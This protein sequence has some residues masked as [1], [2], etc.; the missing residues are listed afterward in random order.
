MNL[1]LR[2]LWMLMSTPFRSRLAPLEV[3]VTRWRVLPGDLDA[4]GHMTN[5]RYLAVMDLARLDLLVRVGLAPLVLRHRWQV[6]VGTSAMEYRASLR[7]FEEYEVATR[8]VSWDSTWFYLRQDF[9]RPGGSSPVA[10][11]Y[12]KILF[13]GGEGPLG[14][15]D[16]LAQLGVAIARPELPRE[17]AAR[18]GAAAAAAPAEPPSAGVAMAS[19]DAAAREPLAICG[20]GC[21]LPGGI[22]DAASLWRALEER[23]DGIVEIP[24][25]RWSPERFFDPSGASA[26]RTYVQRAGLLQRDPRAFDAAFFG[27]NPREA[28]VLDPQQRL[29]LHTSWEALEDAGIPADQLAGSDTGVFI[30]GF[31]VDN[32]ILQTRPDNRGRITSAT[33]TS[34]SLTM[35]SNRLS[36]TYDLRGPSLT[37]D[38]ACSSSLV[39]LHLACQ[40]LWSGEVS[41]ALVGGVNALLV[42]ETQI[43]MAK[44][45][46]LSPRGYCHTFGAAADGY[47]RAEGAAVLVVKPLAAARRDGNPVLA[48]IR[49]TAANQDG[50]TPG[51]T[52][53]QG[54]A[55]VAVMRAAY[56]AARVEPSTVAYLEAHGTGTAAGDPI[57]ARAL[58]AV[59]GRDRVDGPCFIG[60]IKSNLGHL[61][62]ASGVTGVLKAALV[63]RERRVP[64]SLHSEELNPE[65]P[66]AELGVEVARETV[67]LAGAAPLV[68]GVNSFGYGGTNAHVVLG[69]APSAPAAPPADEAARAAATRPAIVT[70]SAKSPAALAEQAERYAAW[71]DEGGDARALARSSSVHRAHHRHRLA[72]H[73][74]LDGAPGEAAALAGAL[75]AAVRG[76]PTEESRAAIAQSS[77]RA[78]APKV[79]FVYTGMGPQWWGMCRELAAAEPVVR[80]TFEECDAIWRELAGWSLTAELA[81]DEADSRVTRTEIAQPA[82]F[83]V[84][85]ALTRLLAS[86]G[87]RPDGVIGHSVGE[88][89]VAAVS[90]GLSLRD[91]LTLAFHRSRLQAK[92]AGAGGMLAVGLSLDE[93]RARQAAWGA[94]ISVA[95]VNGP[96][97]LTLAGD[98]AVLERVAEELKAAGEFARALKVEVPYH[99]PQMEAIR[100]ELAASLRLLAA[101]A[102]ALPVYSTVTGGA[103]RGGRHDAAYWWRNVREP[104]DFVGG[105]AAAAAD[106]YDVFV[107]IGPHPVLASSIRETLRER[108]ADGE[109]VAT[110]VREAPERAALA[111]AVARLYAL[112]VT[113]DWRAYAGPGV[114]AP[115]PKVAWQLE[116][117]WVDSD[118]SARDLHGGAGHPWLGA[119]ARGASATRFPCELNL[120]RGSAFLLDH[121]VGGAPLFPG[122]GYVELA[123][124]ARHAVTGSARCS[125]EGLRFEAPIAL[126]PASAPRLEVSLSA[127][128][129]T[130]AVSVVGASVDDG[131]PVAARGRLRSLGAPTRAVE[132]DATRRRALSEVPVDAL[133]QTLSGSGLSY[134]PAFRGA[135][136]LWRRDAAAE[137]GDGALEVCAALCLPEH[138]DAE[139]YFLH[140]ALL[141]AA[142]HSLLAAVASEYAGAT[143]VPS[144]IERLQWFEPLGRRATMCGALVRLG[145]GELRGEL[146][147][148]GER[149]QVAVE[150]T[151][152]TCRVLRAPDTFAARASRWCSSR[153]FAP[154]ELQPAEVSGV[155]RWWSE[156]ELP[157][158]SEL[159]SPAYI[160]DRRWLRAGAPDR[161]PS[162]ERALAC[163]SELLAAVSAIDPGQVARYFVLTRGAERVAADDGAPDLELAPLLGLCRTVMTERPD[164][165]LTVVDFGAELPDE[166]RAALEGDRRGG[167]GFALQALLASLGEEQELAVRGEQVFA[168]RL[169]PQDLPCAAPPARVPLFGASFDV[170]GADAGSLDALG[171][172]ACERSA[173]GPGQ[174]ELEVEYC[175]LGFKDVMKA[176]G[177][178]PPR[179]LAGT[180]FGERLGME[181][182]G[183]ITRVGA[184]VRDLAVGDRVY[185]S[186]GGFLRSHV[187]AEAEKTL[188]LPDELPSTSALNLINFMTAYS[189][190]IETARL[191]PGEWV[192]IH[193]ATGGVGQAALEVAR[194]RGARVIATA[195]SEDKR[196]ALAAQGLHVASSRELSF[197]DEVARL[198]GGRGVD[199][200]LNFTP[201]E[202]AAKSLESLAPLGRFLEIG[203]M[204][205]E[206]ESVLRLAP[207]NAG[208]TYA[209]CDYDRLLASHPERV[210]AAFRAVLG[211]LAAGDFAAT[212]VTSFPASEVS[213]AFR[214]MARGK[215][216][217]KVAVALRDPE[218]TGAPARAPLV[219]PG[220]YLVTGGLRGFGLEV[221]RHLA[222]SGATAMALCTRTGDTTAEA[223]AALDELRAGGCD[224]RAFAVD[225]GDH[226]SLAATLATVRATM[227]PLRGVV[228]AATVYDDR[229]LE[230]LDRQALDRV[231]R[232]KAGA[233]L[234]LDQLTRGDDLEAFV[235]FSSISSLIGNAGQGNYVAANA[236]LDQLAVAR[237]EAGRPA[238]SIQWGA[239][240][241]AGVVTRDEHLARHLAQLGLRG[242]A[243]ADALRALDGVLAARGA[244]PP[245]IAVIDADWR[246]IADGASAGAARRRL[247]ALVPVEDQGDGA[248]G[249]HDALRGL[250]E[251]A[252]LAS[253]LDQVSAVVSSVMRLPAG[254]LEAHTP[255]REIGIDS[256]L[257][258]EIAVGLEHQLKV[259]VSAM[260][261]AAGP[262]PAE[263]A[264]A[265]LARALA[266]A[267]EARS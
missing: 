32:M 28:E 234:A 26:G 29:L 245:A 137:G 71:L 155:W 20:V 255:L 84:Q 80:Q 23:R 143:I 183:H 99:S 70:V 248:P 239:L 44:G 36:Y 238:V 235:L 198:T 89:T 253:V 95:A 209:A 55:Q 190:L 57:E 181:G 199:V 47:V 251:G 197:A 246:R 11:G 88:V 87:V 165:R 202:I 114:Y 75:R 192:L 16:V 233:A 173:P 133:Y 236:L 164:L 223:R 8:I 78:G 194:W 2:L 105:I 178:L 167:A 175:S 229:P 31:T 170:A 30:G 158:L 258:L 119:A 200:V 60:S 127:E 207:F 227:P 205:F 150:L 145:D 18:L 177:A 125:L 68:A 262:A 14:T 13:R 120:G 4:F 240:G 17:L 83:L 243:T 103:L 136:A 25:E 213:E 134:G 12:V 224:A 5:A 6:P 46:F 111:R 259:P 76:E 210:V 204:S 35:L 147:L 61:E 116:V 157:R 98:R 123:L 65:I 244:C 141:D 56:R 184:G 226:A 179:A 208:L 241:E 225:V 43:M 19:S 172:A 52:M 67:P 96:R 66:F 48:V 247:Q 174:V 139:G 117:P 85:L 124:A 129:G 163:A 266:P 62:A 92:L 187:L 86:W 138:V 59:V 242:L 142:L 144:G 196:A 27:I 45:R 121:V 79:M 39:A 220:T 264:S 171:F 58:G 216:Q 113:P 146:T 104:V 50:R 94:Q 74:A 101:E 260:M 126:D 122:A 203:K 24:A 254:K 162:Y 230:R 214:L 82:N 231:L 201:G 193:G 189:A 148:F 221:A 249:L 15:A 38:T 180:F 112:G 41:T 265:L 217:G 159:R 256:L 91:A 40:S 212:P 252:A 72:W 182:V 118:A 54:D 100:D 42:P 186:V 250:D 218:L 154:V 185:A 110:L 228:H 107:E 237:R 149:G 153:A 22:D 63:L 151:G 115:I 21:R 156:H 77:E 222:R 53:P 64:P 191:A 168:A 206:A 176:V 132:L 49:G 51:I 219:S 261:L 97:A 108:G 188:R 267:P 73:G 257:A 263:I 211:H 37:V 166:L 33:A 34:S 93:V 232:V 128:A 106:G 160:V 69:E 10:T 195:G 131:A 140:P 215:H 102:P 169:L 152:L 9:L 1:Y 130:F 7:L 135:Q 3:G 81:R 161:A 109:L 90:E